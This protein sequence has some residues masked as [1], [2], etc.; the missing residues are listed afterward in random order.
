MSSLTMTP[1]PL[2]ARQ[3]EKCLDELWNMIGARHAYDARGRYISGLR[4]DAIFARASETHEADTNG[5]RESHGAR[6]ILA[7]I[8]NDREGDRSL[9]R[10]SEDPL[11]DVEAEI[12]ARARASI[13]AWTREIVR[14][15]RAEA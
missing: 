11:A 3:M 2:T 13:P 12:I 5:W 7:V 14:Q 1:L 10:Q 15:R 6:L 4:S 8:A 9:A